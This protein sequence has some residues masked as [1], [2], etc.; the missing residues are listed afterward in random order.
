MRGIVRLIRG[1]QEGDARAV[2][3]LIFAILG[4]AV[5]V[6]VAELVRRRRSRQ[7]GRVP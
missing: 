1:L 6:L 4:T 3:V 2:C 5:I 7:N